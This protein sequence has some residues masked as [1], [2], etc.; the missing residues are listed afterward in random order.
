[1][2]NLPWVGDSTGAFNISYYYYCDYGCH[3]PFDQCCI[4]GPLTGPVLDTVH[5]S[6]LYLFLTKVGAADTCFID[7]GTEASRE[8]ITH[9]T[10]RTLLRSAVNT[11]HQNQHRIQLPPDP[12]PTC[13]PLCCDSSAHSCLTLSLSTGSGLGY[14]SASLF[15]IWR[16]QHGCRQCTPRSCGSGPTPPSQVK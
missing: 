6:P 9:P 2:K 13:W 10:K 4:T 14:W 3:F 15:K 1:M 8:W 7:A 11:A 12:D 5:A 16:V